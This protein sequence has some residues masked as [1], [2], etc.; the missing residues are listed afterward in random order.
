MLNSIEFILYF[1]FIIALIRPAVVIMNTSLGTHTPQA[2]ISVNS[3]VKLIYLVKIYP[4]CNIYCPLNG[5]ILSF[6]HIC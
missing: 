4:Q 3:E 6:D 1:K 2:I 5:K